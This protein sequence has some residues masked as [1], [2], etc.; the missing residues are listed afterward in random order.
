LKEKSEYVNIEERLETINED[1]K[2][3]ALSEDQKREL[4]KRQ[5]EKAA[6]FQAK[7]NEEIKM[8]SKSFR[9]TID[10]NNEEEDEEEIEEKVDRPKKTIDASF[11]EKFAQDLEK[12]DLEPKFNDNEPIDVDVAANS[13]FDKLIQEY[14][15]TIDRENNER[16]GKRLHDIVIA[17]NK[18]SDGKKRVKWSDK[19]GTRFFS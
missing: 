16:M 17:N 2:K 4:R 15:K 10:D 6:Q 1:I 14:D 7:I 19:S 18:G 11:M 9:Q 8:N 5:Q 12:L 3:A 13:N